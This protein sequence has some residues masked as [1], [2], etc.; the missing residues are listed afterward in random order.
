MATPFGSYRGGY[1]VLPPEWMQTMTQV[2]QNYAKGMQNLGS[3][4]ESAASSFKE[5]AEEK[6]INQQQAPLNMARYQ[7]V[8]KLTGNEVDS[9]LLDRYNKIGQMGSFELGQ[10]NKSLQDATNQALL[11][12]ELRRKQQA[13]QMQQ[14]ALQ[15]ASQ[16]QGLQ[17]RANSINQFVD[18]LPLPSMSAP[19][20]NALIP[21]RPYP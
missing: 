17:Q 15:R 10:F 18:S 14:S 9:T 2:G 3:S 4:L 12:D 11:I 20:S 19:A 6:Y 21:F 8:A 16:S 7:Q 13:F 1:Q 5:G